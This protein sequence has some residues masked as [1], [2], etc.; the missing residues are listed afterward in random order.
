MENKLFM[1]I[2]LKVDT[3]VFNIN[4]GVQITYLRQKLK[5]VKNINQIS[6]GENNIPF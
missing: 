1:F 2:T 4:T 3:A 6:K 5:F